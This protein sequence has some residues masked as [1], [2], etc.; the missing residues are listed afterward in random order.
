MFALC[1]HWPVRSYPWGMAE[2]LRSK[3]SDVL[4]LKRLLFELSSFDSLKRRTDDR[5]YTFRSQKLADM[6]AATAAAAAAAASE[7][8]LA[9]QS[10]TVTMNDV[11][12]RRS[13]AVLTHVVSSSREACLA[14]ACSSEQ[15][16]I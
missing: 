5:Y 7:G 9:H 15:S 16:A 12:A 2:A 14:A 6:V 4:A 8:A 13:A 3:H 11:S 1:R 10:R